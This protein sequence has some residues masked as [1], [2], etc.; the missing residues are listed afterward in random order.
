[1]DKFFGQI[2]TALAGMTLRKK[3]SL[4]VVIG[5]TVGGLTYLVQW[6]GRPDFQRLYVD[7]SM[8]DAGQIVDELKSQKVPYQVTAGGTGIEVPA[9]KVYELRMAMASKGLPM[10]T[11]LPRMYTSPV[12]LRSPNSRSATVCVPEPTRPKRPRISPLCNSKETL[13]E[14]SSDISST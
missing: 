9:Q 7:L 3:I 8:D 2:G 14:A 11:F 12:P 13:W 10:R 5:L 4:L 6:S 1:M